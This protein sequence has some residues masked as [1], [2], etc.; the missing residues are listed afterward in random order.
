VQIAAE[1]HAHAHHDEGPGLHA[2]HPRLSS[3]WGKACTQRTCL[4]PCREGTWGALR[5]LK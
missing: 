4:S 5:A 3:P 2:A 1:Q